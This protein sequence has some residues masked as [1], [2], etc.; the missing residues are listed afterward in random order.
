MHTHQVSLVLKQ[1]AQAT[2]LSLCLMASACAATANAD[3]EVIAPNEAKDIA[4]V[5]TGIK[6][7]VQKTHAQEG[8]AFRD[9]HRKAHGCVSAKFTVLGG[10]PTDLAQGVLAR[11]RSF[12]AVIRYSNG[13]QVVDDTKGDA[14]GMAIKLMGI[15]GPKLLGDEAGARTQD[16][17]LM[18]SPVFFVRNAK[19]YV[20]FQSAISNGGLSVAGWLA[21]HWREA[22]V[23]LSIQNRKVSNPLNT[24]YWSP[25]PSRLGTQQIK[26]SAVPCAGQSFT[27]VSTGQHLLRENMEAHLSKQGA[28]FD[29]MVQRRA[30]PKQMP[31]EDATVEWKESAAPF[32]KV[33]R[34]DIASQA[35]EQGEACEIRSFT[36]WHSIEAHRPLGGI[37]RTRKAVYQAISTLRHDLNGQPRVEP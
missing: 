10:L 11:P 29:F 17:L 26:Y 2:G 34:I 23:L 6:A 37:E 30:Q 13:S 19:D 32:V 12:D 9:A 35:P 25:T 1:V 5:V 21:L 22:S 33:A 7:L 28:C 14:R 36:P 16:F 4:A 27:D 18:T 24:R 8:R 20:G 15:D 31:I 3:G